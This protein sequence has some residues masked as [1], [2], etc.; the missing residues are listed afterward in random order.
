MGSNFQAGPSQTPPPPVAPTISSDPMDESV[1]EGAP[2]SFSVSATGTPVLSYQWERNTIALPGEMAATLTIASA[3][4]AD[5]GA[6]YR[7]V[8][9][10][11]HGSATSAAATL[12]VTVVPVNDPPTA[13]DD[14]YSLDEGASLAV[15]AGAGVLFNDFDPDADPLEAVLLTSPSHGSLSLLADGSFSYQHDGSETTSDVF[16]YE[17]RDNIIGADSATVTLTITP[18]NDLPTSAPDGYT[19][20]PGEL[21]AIDAASGVLGNDSDAEGSVLSAVLLADVTHGTLD[22]LPDGSFTYQHADDGSSQ[23][24]FS[25]AAFDGTD[26]GPITQ[27]TIGITSR[28][29]AGLQALYDFSTGNSSLVPDR[30]DVLP[31][32]DLTIADE[33]AVTWIPGG[34]LSIDTPTSIV[35]AGPA[36]RLGAALQASEGLTIEAWVTPVEALAQFGPA[37]IVAYS[38]DGFPHGGNFVLGQTYDSGTATAAYA[39]RLRTTAT[40]K[41][42]TPNLESPF[43][44]TTATLTHV[45][46]TRA[47]G[48]ATAI[49]LDGI[50]VATGT[51]GGTFASFDDVPLALANEPTGGRG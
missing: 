29:S 19:A 45:V 26:Q 41:Y 34:G 31:A 5:D 3:S 33:S 44:S 4:L 51:R 21:I 50:E 17:A 23:D 48:G 47:P 8:V 11:A 14:D 38:E 12:T 10:N 15:A 24:Q 46:Y 16:T 22:L 2:A 20:L 37:R 25:Y 43:G 35:S 7:C 27:V 30:S 18:L 6:A 1:F 40:N 36:T 42:G 49:Y 39:A 32:L 13:A 9:S 28:I